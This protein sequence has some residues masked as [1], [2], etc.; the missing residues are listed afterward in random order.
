MNT[1]KLFNDSE[2]FVK[3]RPTKLS[4][5]RKDEIYKTLAKEIIHNGWSD[6]DVD[7]IVEDLE[8]LYRWDSGYEKAKTL[9]SYSSKASYEIETSFIEWLDSFEIE[10]EMAIQENVKLWVKAHNIK[11]KFQIGTKLI[12]RQE[13]SRN[14][15][16]QVEK[17]IYVNGYHEELAM[18]K[19]YPERESN[20]NILINYEL[21]ENN[22]EL[23]L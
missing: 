19:V 5:E 22:C 9:E 15:E 17:E 16:L 20:S 1:L 13:F 3:E 8:G 18:Y 21:V 2:V 12:V 23:K 10:F 7:S 4:K 6:D 11:P 14:V